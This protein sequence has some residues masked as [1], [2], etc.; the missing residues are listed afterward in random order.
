[1][2]SQS[3]PSQSPS[4]CRWPSPPSRWA[5]L[6]YATRMMSDMLGFAC[7]LTEQYGDMVRFRI[8][9]AQMFVVGH[10]ERI[11]DVLVRQVDSFIR[12]PLVQKFFR[13]WLGRGILLSD[14]EQW[15]KQR[16]PVQAAWHQLSSEAS[17][18]AAVKHTRRLLI[19]RCGETFDFAE[20]CERLAFAIVY[21]TVLGPAAPAAIDAMFDAATVLQDAGIQRLSSFSQTPYWV[22]TGGN[23]RLRQALRELRALLDNHLQSCRVHSEPSSSEPSNRGQFARLMLDAAD[24]GEMS[25][26]AVRDGLANL[27]FGGKETAGASLL[28]CLYLLASHPHAQTQAQ[29]EIDAILP[30]R[31]AAAADYERLP[32]LEQVYKESLRLYPAVP[33]LSRQATR[34]VNLAGY[35]VPKRG[36]V[37][38]AVHCMQRDKRWFPEPDQF[39]PERFQREREKT[40][41]AHAFLPFGA[42]VHACIGRRLA[43]L[44][45][46]IV[47]AT[48]LAETSVQLPENHQL[49]RLRADLR[50]HPLG[51]FPL[52]LSARAANSPAANVGQGIR[53]RSQNNAIR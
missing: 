48:L 46:S 2:S 25:S 44:E 23:R 36:H 11:H 1:M 17:A 31:P 14:G 7:E 28:F 20:A 30:G 4:P 38:L 18:A 9:P 19:A 51:P 6:P 39:L 13:P 21:E 33:F 40:I 47:L 26:Q 32:Y 34:A 10:P 24:R 42:G 16:V 52:Q 37:V 5:G 45:A 12:E 8:G 50:L 3:Q 43:M 49:P 53:S 27:L 35:T 15:R 41:P 29:Q 22:P